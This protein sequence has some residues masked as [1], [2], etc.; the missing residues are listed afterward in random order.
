MS[1]SLTEFKGS[2]T[3]RSNH[4]FCHP[5]LIRERPIN[6]RSHQ[7]FGGFTPE[8][9]FIPHYI[10]EA[11]LMFSGEMNALSRKQ[12]HYR[13]PQELCDASST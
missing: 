7:I 8:G 10:D 6:K 11:V 3:K 13:T 9:V 12:L 2:S 5:Y 1:M 4:L